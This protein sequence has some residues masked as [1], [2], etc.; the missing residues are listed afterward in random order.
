[1]AHEQITELAA[2]LLANPVIEQFSV[3]PG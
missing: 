1:V 3:H 2:E